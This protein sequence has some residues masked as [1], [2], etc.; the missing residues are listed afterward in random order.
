MFQPTKINSALQEAFADAA[1]FARSRSVAGARRA[2]RASVP[3]LAG[4]L[5]SLPALAQ[6][7]A[8]A[9]A[10]ETM[11]RVTITGSMIPRTSAETAEAITVISADSLKDMGITTVEQALQQVSSNQST[12]LTSSSVTTWGTGGGSFASLRGLGA[13]RTLVLLDG[14]RL[15]SNAQVD[16]SADLNSIPFAAIDRIEVLREGASSVYGADAIAGVI[17]FITKKDLTGGQLNLTGVKAVNKGG[18]SYG[19]DLSYGLGNLA[20]DGYNLMGTIS[21]TKQDELRALQRGFSQR[22]GADNAYYTAPAS[23]SDSNGNIFSVDYPDC[24]KSA[25]VNQSYLNTANGYCGYQYTS[26]TDLIPQSSVTSGMLQLTKALNAENT[27]K[28]QYFATQSRVKTWGGAYSYDIAMNPTTDA[29]YFPTAAS[30]SPNTLYGTAGSTPNLSSDIDVLWTD[31]DNNRYQGD[32]ATQQRFLATLTGSHGDWDYQTSVSFN[33]NISTVFLDG[34]YPDTTLLT[35]TD[36]NG[37]QVLN[38]AINPFGAQ[39]AA[40]QAVINDSYKSGSLDTARLRMWDVNASASHPVGDWFK[41]GAATLA[42]GVGARGEQI[43]SATSDLADTMSSETGYYPSSVTGK[44][45]SEAV[46]GELNVPVFKQLEL[47]VSDR[48]DHYSDFGSTN[49]AKL[50]FRFQPSKL[51]AFRGAVSTGFRAPSLVDMYSP[52]VLAASS[53][54]SGSVC[55]QF[56]NIC[57]SQGMQVTGGN[58][59]LKPEKSDN[60]DFGIVLAP[61]TNLGITLDFYR[62]TISNQITTLSTSTIYKNYD[63]FSDLYHLNNSGT[64][65]IAGDNSCNAG[66]SAPTCGY[67]ERTVQ[68]SGGVTTNG[69]DISTNYTLDTALGRFRGGLEGTWVSQY[70]LQAYQGAAWQNIRGN[71]SGGYEPV[72]AWQ[73]SL[74]LDWSK[75]AWGGGLSNHYESGY[76]DENTDAD[77]NSRKVRP[78][79]TWN[80]YG[81]WKATKQLTLLVGMRNMFNKTPSFSNQSDQWQEGFNPVFGDPV[82]RALYGKLTLDF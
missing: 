11:Q 2:T 82:G 21:Y 78:Y 38:P 47:T 14:Q 45:T 33:Q 42:L 10:P 71:Y 64:L 55:N 61:A 70:K 44:R 22:G 26:A 51:I 27:L 6:S 66:I 32:R 4:A 49:N 31:P 39:T 13:S 43:H 76:I 5:F 28:L 53:T 59:N 46:Y 58:R 15:T 73:D 36:G 68:N 19:A 25:G 35:V 56:A 7:A 77:G 16:S 17:N 65:S 67:I 54:F 34:G 57:G 30:S 62:V 72:L 75:G 81:S 69:I 9:D 60:Y 23:Y 52:E 50:S 20:T 18:N 1:A 12:T 37:D 41:A 24:G 3:L 8:A 80:T 63:T 29:A 48:E 74:T 79:T 40:G